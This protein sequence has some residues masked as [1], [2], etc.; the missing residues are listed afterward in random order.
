MHSTED[1]LLHALKSRGPLPT[2]AVARQLGITL[3]GARKHLLALT[4]S[5]LVASEMVAT[6]VGRPKRVWIS[7]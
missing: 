4:E 5:G 7:Y 6:G 2:Q 3:P 1:R